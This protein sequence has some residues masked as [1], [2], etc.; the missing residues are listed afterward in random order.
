MGGVLRKTGV[1]RRALAGAGALLLS[2]RSRPRVASRPL[3]GFR[4]RSGHL[5]LRHLVD[6]PDALDLRPDRRLPRRGRSARGRRVD[7]ALPRAFRADRGPHA[8]RL[9]AYDG[10]LG[11]PVGASRA[12]ARLDVHRVSVESRRLCLGR[13]AGRAADH[14]LDRRLGA[15]LPDRLRQCRHRAGRAAA[16]LGARGGRRGSSADLARHGRALGGARWR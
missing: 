2:A 3:A 16:A 9:A 10:G 13:R 4:A 14:R 8:R 6:R 7:G 15:L 12:L 11:G 1:R 5:A